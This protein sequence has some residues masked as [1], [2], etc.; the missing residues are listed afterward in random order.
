V[1]FGPDKGIYHHALAVA[2][3]QAG[4]YAEAQQV[5]RTAQAL[6]NPEHP[7]QQQLA[8]ILG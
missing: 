4:R 7:V 2:L 8:Q 3:H 1:Q 5:A 6:L